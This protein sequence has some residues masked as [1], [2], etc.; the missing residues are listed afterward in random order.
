MHKD[1]ISFNLIPLICKFINITAE[2]VE[3]NV[4]LQKLA[5]FQKS[6]FVFSVLWLC[7]YFCRER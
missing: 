6:Q 2:H 5:P 1:A 4:I 3:N 7:N